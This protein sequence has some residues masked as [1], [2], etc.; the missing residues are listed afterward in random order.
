[1][2]ILKS[3]DRK[4]TEGI[5]AAEGDTIP[6]GN[7]L[8]RKILVSLIIFVVGLA[9]VLLVWYAVSEIYNTYFMKT[10]KFPTIGDAF[11][12]LGHYLN[13]AHKL[14]GFTLYEH[15]SAS[16]QRWLTGFSVAFVIGMTLGL[17]MGLNDRIYRFG[18][19]PV[20]ILQMIPGLAWFPV[21]IL[22]FG[23]GNNSAVFIIAVTVISPIA[24]N[25]AAGLR[26]VPK[27][28]LRVAKMIGRTRTERLAEVLIPFSMV[29]IIG[30][31]RIGM[32][33]SWRM[34][35]AAEMVVGV[36]VGL[37][38]MINQTTNMTNYPAAFAGI[39]IICII[40]LTIDKL[41]FS[42]VERYAREKL[43]LE[44]TK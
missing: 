3:T 18:S 21:T 43:G 4:I 16:L 35:I 26:R 20:N 11:G 17:L 14:L 8:P 44:E 30:G 41:I 37:G 38:Y 23:F 42:N 31:L 25:V 36:A 1:M 9:F 27:V 7:P 34:L 6:L 19:V 40:G 32:A 5:A 22:L 2:D 39:I 24:F 13:D 15:L 28:N 12:T 33:N 29:D 10:L